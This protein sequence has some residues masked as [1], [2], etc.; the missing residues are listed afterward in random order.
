MI[1]RRLLDD[2]L[3]TVCLLLD[4]F[5]ETLEILVIVNGE[6]LRDIIKKNP[7]PI[8]ARAVGIQRPFPKQPIDF[9][10]SRSH[11]VFIIK[12]KSLNLK[13]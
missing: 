4:D 3:M 12:E 9:N 13:I 2:C 11:Q 8:N 7:N 10:F 5:L 6:W 1:A